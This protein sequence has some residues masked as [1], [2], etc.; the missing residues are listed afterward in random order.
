MAGARRTGRARQARAETGKRPRRRGFRAGVT[1]RERGRPS[2]ERSQRREPVRSRTGKGRN[3]KENKKGKHRGDW[4]LSIQ[5]GNRGLK[6]RVGRGLDGDRRWH[7]KGE[8]RNTKMIETGKRD[9]WGD[10]QQHL[11]GGSERRYARRV[12]RG[13]EDKDDTRRRNARLGFE[14]RS[15]SSICGMRRGRAMEREGER[16]SGQ[17]PSYPYS[18]PLSTDLVQLQMLAMLQQLATSVSS[19]ASH[20]DTMEGWKSGTTP[21]LIP[22]V[23]P[24]APSATPVKAVSPKQ[25]AAPTTAMRPP[26]KVAGLVST[27]QAGSSLPDPI[28]PPLASDVVFPPLAHVAPL[29]PRPQGTAPRAAPAK[30]TAPPVSADPNNGSSTWGNQGVTQHERTTATAKAVASAQG[31]TLAGTSLRKPPASSLAKANTAIAHQTAKPLRLLYGHWSHEADRT[32]NFVYVLAGKLTMA[33]ILPYQEWLCAPFPGASLVPSEGWFWAQLRGVITHSDTGKFFL[34]DELEAELRLHPAFE[35][36]LFIVQPHWLTHPN[37]IR[38]A[39][40][41]VG[42]AMEDPTGAVMQAAMAG[43]V[44]MFSYQVKFV[45]CGDLPTLIQCGRCYMIGHCTNDKACKWH[46]DQIRCQCCGLDH[47]IDDHHFECP[48][49]HTVLGVCK[50]KYKC[51]LCGEMGHDAH[52]RKCSKHGDFPAPKLAK[53]TGHSAPPPALPQGSMA[54]ECEDDPTNAPATDDEVAAAGADALA[55][56]TVNYVDW[57]AELNLSEWGETNTSPAAAAVTAA[58]HTSTPSKP[59][60][61]HVATA[62]DT[63]KPGESSTDRTIARQTTIHTARP[64]PIP[65]KSYNAA[66]LQDARQVS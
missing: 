24:V 16:E 59:K 33:Q 11:A 13:L 46:T 37:N 56:A 34:E 57:G 65:A 23:V 38:E 3:E 64:L 35:T 28:T 58:F 54:P 63:A 36:V 61:R 6:Y 32:G 39:T 48:N 45:P 53:V 43:P 29:P 66:A 5:Q 12:G 44:S 27:G 18:V 4:V 41:T 17:R 7:T 2:L 8:Q 21:S 9:D 50:C 14:C 51:L 55:N 31:R 49:Q 60:A 15:A 20:V 26:P 30:P 22:A 40:A 19:L 52:S 47:H 1:E 42:F 25:A 10:L 62:T